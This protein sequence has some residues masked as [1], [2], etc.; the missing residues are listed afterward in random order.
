[1]VDEEFIPQL[2]NEHDGYC[3]VP[4]EKYPKPLHPGVWRTFKF[5]VIIN[6]IKTI[7][8]IVK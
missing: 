3:W 8:K 2:N 5:D 4:L 6:K 7:E 1:V